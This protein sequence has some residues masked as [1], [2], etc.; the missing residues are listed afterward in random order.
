MKSAEKELKIKKDEF[1]Q[2]GWVKWVPAVR[3]IIKAIVEAITHNEAQ[4]R[5]LQKQMQALAQAIDRVNS[6]RGIEEAALE[7][8]VSL[9]ESWAN[10]VQDAD[11]LSGYLNVIKEVPETAFVFTMQAMGTWISLESELDT[12]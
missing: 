6:A 4:I 7:T 9:T 11:D 12:W 2:Y 1:A 8:I 3:P 5:D 10:L